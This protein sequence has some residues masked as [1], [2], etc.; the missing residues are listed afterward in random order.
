MTEM[1]EP[2]HIAVTFPPGVHCG[3]VATAHL[4]AASLALP[5]ITPWPQTAE[6]QVAMVPLL[7]PVFQSLEKSATVE[8]RPLSSSP[9]QKSATFL[10]S[11]LLIATFQACFP[12]SIENHCAPACHIKPWNQPVLCGGNAVM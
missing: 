10:D 12:S 9:C 7:S 2:P 8:T 1:A 5:E 11:G 3:I 4:P 6:T